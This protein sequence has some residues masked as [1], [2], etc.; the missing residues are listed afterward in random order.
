MAETA[1]TQVRY[2]RF[3]RTT[4]KRLTESVITKPQVTLHRRA[5]LTALESALGPARSADPDSGVG[6]TA[7]L[8]AAVARA[9]R[10]SRING[11]VTDRTI[12]LHTGVHLGVA[13]DVAGALV[14]PVIRDADRLSVAGIGSELRRLSELAR[15][16]RLRM[17]DIADATFTVSSLGALGVEFFSPIVNPPQLAIL[18]VGAVR[19]ELA[20]VD[21]QVVAVRRIG[22]SLS[23]D[24]A[25]TDGA[26]AARVLDRI[27]RGVEAADDLLRAGN[28]G[29]STD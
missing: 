21:D 17:E 19:S 22:L 24:H 9:V 13:V 1:I 6:L 28:T 2:D 23:F 29:N 20:L 8:L 11:T 25:A 16:G 5:E 12:D 4:A 7:A 3:R 14:V 15:A 18:G 26:D 10:A 27:C